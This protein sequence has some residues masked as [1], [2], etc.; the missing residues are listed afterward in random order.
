MFKMCPAAETSRNS[1][2]NPPYAWA[3]SA[4]TAAFA[5]DHGSDSRHYL[6]KCAPE[7]VYTM[8]RLAMT[9][10]AALTA[11]EAMDSSLDM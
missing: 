2:L 1:R 7:W 11:D 3:A 5:G 8:I 10:S 6:S 9:L 4:H